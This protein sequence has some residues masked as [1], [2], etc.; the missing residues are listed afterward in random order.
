VAPEMI[1]QSN[2]QPYQLAPEGIP[3]DSLMANLN[4]YA[5]LLVMSENVVENPSDILLLSEDFAVDRM[6]VIE[7]DAARA[8]ETVRLK[9]YDIDNLDEI[10]ANISVDPSVR[11]LKIDESGVIDN[12]DAALGLIVGIAM[13]FVLYMFIL[14]YGQLVMQSIIEEKNNRVLELIVTSIKPRQLMLGK[15]IGMGAVA[16]TQVAVWGLLI[17]VIVKFALPSILGETVFTELEGMMNGTLDLSAATTSPQLLQSLAILSSLGYIF[18]IFGY[19]M[20][21]L[22]GGFMFYAAIY[23][24]IGASVDNAQDGAQLQSFATFPIIIALVLSMSVAQAP[25]SPLAVWLSIIPFTSPMVMMMR[26]QTATPLEMIS[27]IALLYASAAF[28]VWFA[29]KIYRVGIFMYG[30]K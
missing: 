18:Q 30:K 25:D 26:L 19:L 6:I 2:D 23:A 11:H 21:Y 5:P 16:L 8:I 3:V 27:S 13:A 10:I 15:L 20:V 29:A 1:A 24:A 28:V 17:A 14:I 22:V 12:S 4:D 9:S 7:D